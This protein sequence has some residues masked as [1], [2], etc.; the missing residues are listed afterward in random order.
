[1]PTGVYPRTSGKKRGPRGDWKER[2][3][4]KVDKN[5]PV[6]PTLGKC[7]IW[8]A[9][10]FKSGYGQFRFNDVSMTAHCVSYWLDG[11]TIPTGLHI[12]HICRN[13]LCVNPRH[14]RT[15]TCKQ[16]GE[17]RAGA[18]RNNK[19]SGVRGVTRL[20]NGRW[21]GQVTHSGTWVN[22]GMFDTI[23]EAEEAVV[24][25]RLELFTHNDADRLYAPATGAKQ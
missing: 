15:V 6:H 9:G 1:M 19:S 14:L 21:R 18:N 5:G 11:K 17:N 2:F 23:A 16:N 4:S 25:K 10:I 13:R 8:T 20:K 12:D 24:A 7:W 22:C 3:W